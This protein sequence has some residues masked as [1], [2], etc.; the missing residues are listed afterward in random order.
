MTVESAGA[1]FRRV[2]AHMSPAAALAAKFAGRGAVEVVGSGCE[3]RLSDGRQAL[4]FG[5]Y[6]VTL[7]GHRHPEVVGAVIRQLAELPVSTRTLANPATARAAEDVVTYLGSTLPRVYFGTNGADAVELAVKLARLATGRV[8]VLAVRGAYHGKSLGALALTWHPRFRA[9]LEP[10]LGNVIHADPRDVDAVRDAGELAAVIFEPVQG[11][12][13]VQV[14]DRDVLARWIG[15]AHASGAMVIADEIQVG[16]RRGGPRSI[17][18]DAGL[19]VDAVLL[20]KPLGGGVMP[21]SAAVCSDAL[22]Q[23]L[24]DDPFRHTATFGAQPLGMAAVSAALEVIEANAGHGERVSG[25][26]AAGLE[27][28]RTAHPEAVGAVRGRGLI[29][30]VDFTSAEYAGEVAL[31]LVEGGLLV[32]PCLSRPTTLRLLPPIIATD[33][34]VTRAVETL[35]DAVS[36]AHRTVHTGPGP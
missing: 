17:S 9:G 11:E 25:R 36:Y 32:S 29:W 23:P 30:G 14:L 28:L 35:F 21:V 3:V 18:L 27:A 22:Y 31:R 24:A 26:M 13:G 34:E 15:D 1:T 12:N 20:G 8:R 4:D 6:A 16:L 2:R 5:S 7:L 19:D 33:G 10:L